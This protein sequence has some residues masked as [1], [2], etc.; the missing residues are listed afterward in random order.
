M[1][2]VV[3]SK[4]KELLKGLDMMTAGDLSDALSKHVED[5]LK[6]AAKRAQENGRKTVR[7]CDL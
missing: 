1:S 2:Y 7:A 4:V 5:S 6:K 3:A